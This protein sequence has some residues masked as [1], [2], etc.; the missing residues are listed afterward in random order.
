M[1]GLMGPILPASAPAG[2]GAAPGAASAASSVTLERARLAVDGIALRDRGALELRFGP[3]A[4]RLD[5]TP[6]GVELRVDAGPRAIQGALDPAALADAVRARGV[7]VVRAE[8]R[9]GGER[10]ED[11]RRPRR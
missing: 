9:A 4:V 7:P 2:A 11:G 10:R 3:E 8:V 6:A 5:A 1:A